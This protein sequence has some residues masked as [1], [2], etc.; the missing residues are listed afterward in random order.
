M[1]YF[2]EELANDL[3]TTIN[4]PRKV[5]NKTKMFFIAKYMKLIMLRIYLGGPII[6]LEAVIQFSVVSFLES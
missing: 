4:E 6:K 1:I 5:M 3:F 2:Y